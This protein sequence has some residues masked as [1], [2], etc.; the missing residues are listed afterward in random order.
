MWK[1]TAFIICLYMLQLAAVAQDNTTSFIRKSGFI[2]ESAPF[3]SCHASTLAETPQGI[4]AAWFGGTDEKEDDVE[5]WFSRLVSGQWTAPVS[6]ANGIQSKSKRYP[7]W[8]PVLYQVPGGPLLLFYKCGPDPIH[9]WGEMKSSGD[10]GK[11]WSAAT[12]LPGHILGPI[13]NKPV[14]LDDG[15]LIC[16]SSTEY[17]DG[18]WE[19]HLEITKDFGK[20]WTRTAVLNDSNWHIIQP[21]VLI[22]PGN[23]LQLLCRSQENKVVSIWSDDYGQSWKKPGTINLPNPN[24][25]TDAVTLKNGLQLLVY[26]HTERYPG[27]WGGPRSPLNVAISKD[28]RNWK[29]ILTLE[30]R[31]GEYSYPAVIQSKDGSIHIT[32]TW[33]R[34]KIR[35]VVLNNIPE[36]AADLR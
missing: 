8:N 18:R 36:Q 2:Y 9:W 28:G 17:T 4:V 35:Y 14:L 12:R 22:H 13:K 5:I 11:T 26:N 24:S 7:T 29:Q 30:D 31:P 33:Q 25:G 3:P 27:K 21:S 1:P 34:K 19:V 32:Y 16:P 15:R 10:H 6:I 23:K 20:T